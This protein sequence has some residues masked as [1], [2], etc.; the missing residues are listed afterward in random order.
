MRKREKIYPPLPKN[1]EPMMIIHELSHI[2]RKAMNDKSNELFGTA[3]CSDIMR[4]LAHEDGITQLDLVKIT[5]YSA[6]SISVSVQKLEEAGYVSR[7]ADTVDHRALRV[8]IT[9]KGKAAEAEM[10]R[11]IKDFDKQIMVG[12]PE[13]RRALLIETLL[14]MRQNVLPHEK[15]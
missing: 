6:P 3:V 15:K 12:I 2:M 9:E 11:T 10:Y 13:D 14:S 8:F 4:H 7:S 1:P 5:H